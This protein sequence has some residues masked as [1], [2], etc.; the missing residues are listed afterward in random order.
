M[1]YGAHSSSHQ[2][3]SSSNPFQD[4]KAEG[5]GFERPSL[6]QRSGSALRTGPRLLGPK[7]LRSSSNPF[8]DV[9]AEGEGFEPPC[10]VKDGGFQV[11]CLTVRLT[12]QILFFNIVLIFCEFFPGVFTGS[13]WT[14]VSCGTWHSI[15]FLVRISTAF[16]IGSTYNRSW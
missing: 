6:S 8:Q 7:R 10:P 11:H 4:V 15:S 13:Y 14:R 12:L 3:R 5:E 16:I 9:K 1:L 2:H